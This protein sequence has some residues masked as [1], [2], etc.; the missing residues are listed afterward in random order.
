M[1]TVDDFLAQHAPVKPRPLPNTIVPTTDQWGR[2]NYE[3]ALPPCEIVPDADDQGVKLVGVTSQLKPL[4]NDFENYTAKVVAEFAVDNSTAWLQ[5]DRAAAVDLIQYSKKR[6]LRKAADRGSSV[7]AVIDAVRSGDYSYLTQNG[8]AEPFMAAVRKFV[9]QAQPRFLLGEI[10]VVNRT[11]GY[12]GSFD[13]IGELGCAPHLGVVLFDWKSRGKHTVYEDNTAQ[14]SAYAHAE[15]YV[16]DGRRH[17]LPQIDSG[18]VVTFLDDGTYAIHPIDLEAAWP[19]A[20]TAIRCYQLKSSTKAIGKP[21][22]AASAPTSDDDLLGQLE[23]SLATTPP[24]DD[25]LA[26]MLA[27]PADA[28]T[29]KGE[30]PQLDGAAVPLA[31][32]A[33]EP[34]VPESAGPAAFEIV[35]WLRARVEAIRDGLAGR[36]VPTDWP[37]GVPTFKAGG[38]TTTTHCDAIEAWC[39][40]VEKILGLPFGPSKPGPVTP[41]PADLV[42]PPSTSAHDHASLKARFEAVRADDLRVAATVEARELGVADV[43]RLDTER[44]AVLAGVIERMESSWEQR[45][46]LVAS[47]LAE[48][49][50]DEAQAFVDVIAPPEP[51]P[52]GG[53]STHWALD[54]LEVDHVER[55]EHL[56]GLV[57]AGVLALSYDSGTGVADTAVVTIPEAALQRLIEAFGGKQAALTAAR[58]AAKAAGAPGPRA[59]TDVAGNPGLLALTLRRGGAAA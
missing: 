57:D 18:A 11:L 5:L 56:V 13:A 45:K 34:V 40:A 7:H 22:V 25:D 58:D 15:Y 10:A 32:S 49:A 19:L 31:A 4:K 42:G 52:H 41:P 9:E 8:D 59:V 38:P 47:L 37:A 27:G 35:A 46:A 36:G 14:L 51:D 23:Q 53:S 44:L 43:E 28:S 16:L 30:E 33:S 20:Q 55:L 3:D 29:R 54:Q 39:D 21:F 17:R 6:M 1:T 2:H 26:A 48:Y 24:V 50:D 12:A